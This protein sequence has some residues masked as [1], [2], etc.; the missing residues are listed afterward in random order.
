MVPCPC[1]VGGYPV[2]GDA[3]QALVVEIVAQE[4]FDFLWL[5]SYY[6]EVLV[7]GDMARYLNVALRDLLNGVAPVCRVVRPC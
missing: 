2:V 5:G 7:S 6:P 3:L 1:V 4:A